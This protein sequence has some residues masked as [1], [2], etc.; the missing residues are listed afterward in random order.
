M[1]G[2]AVKCR[3]GRLLSFEDFEANIGPEFLG[4]IE[5]Y[6]FSNHDSPPAEV[7]GKCPVFLRMVDIGDCG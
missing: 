4:Q 6:V 2:Q 7:L 5:K 1:V 3:T